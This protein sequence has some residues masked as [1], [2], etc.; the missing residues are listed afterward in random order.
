[1]TKNVTLG[2]ALLGVLA[3]GPAFAHH[4]PAALGT[5]RITQ[6]VMAGGT[7]LQPGT[8][9]VRDTGEHVKPLPGQSPD[10]QAWIEFLSGGKVMAR[11]VAELMPSAGRPV[12]TSGG[13]STRL[14]V[15]R[16]KGDE[17]VRVS[18]YHN[19]ERYLIHLPM[20]RY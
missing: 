1:M 17:F 19:G 14:R 8:Y 6:P 20:A 10:A 3:A 9:E 13:S 11:D 12:G 16:L 7:L 15:E 5:V 2:I 18:T 4:A